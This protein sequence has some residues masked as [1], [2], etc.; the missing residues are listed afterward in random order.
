ML[1]LRRVAI[2]TPR[3]NVVYLARDCPIYRAEKF[4]GLAKIE[5]AAN[6]R[7]V[8]AVLNISDNAL[9]GVY[10]N[11][12]RTLTIAFIIGITIWYKSAKACRWP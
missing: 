11:V 5:I 6:G 4:Q 8:L 2:D 7:S 1:K 3:E 9:G 12:F 10:S